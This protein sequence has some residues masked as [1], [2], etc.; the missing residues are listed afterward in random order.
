MIDFF[1]SDDSELGRSNLADAFRLGGGDVMR[2]ET[3]EI[4]DFWLKIDFGCWLESR[5][6]WGMLKYISKL[7]ASSHGLHKM[8]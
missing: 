8:Q 3:S 7:K 5:T 4:E 1:A 6:S 2:S